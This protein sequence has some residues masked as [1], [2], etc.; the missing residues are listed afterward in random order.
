MNRTFTLADLE[1]LLD[2]YGSDAHA[3]PRGTAESV[4][5]LVARDDKARR[6]LAASRSL[7]AD[8]RILTTPSPVHSATVGRILEGVR[9]RRAP[10]AA[11]RLFTP[12][13]MAAFAFAAVG[14][15]ALGATL[16]L[17]I[18]QQPGQSYSQ[19]EDVAVLVLGVDQD[20]GFSTGDSL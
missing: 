17:V 10:Q 19:G 13:R 1:A 15:I 3:W 16:G 6:L 8:L 20:D 9:E 12:V 4:G 18:D 5:A 11:I 7:D 14:C 2:R